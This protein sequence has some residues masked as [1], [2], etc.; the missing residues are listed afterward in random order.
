MT[1][2]FYPEETSSRLQI[3]AEEVKP[4]S[5]CWVEGF[6]KILPWVLELRP[7]VKTPQHVLCCGPHHLQE[8]QAGQGQVMRRVLDLRPAPG[9]LSLR[10]R[11]QSSQNPGDSWQPVFE[12]SL[13]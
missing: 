3:G 5:S 11:G 12:G 1:S 6:F 4:T 2:V 8:A 10:T 9:P 13:L 7:E